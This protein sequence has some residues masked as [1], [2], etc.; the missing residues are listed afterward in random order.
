V[1]H[2]KFENWRVTHS[3][4]LRKAAAPFGAAAFLVVVPAFAEFTARYLESFSLSF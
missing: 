1:Y 2:G 3:P 4:T